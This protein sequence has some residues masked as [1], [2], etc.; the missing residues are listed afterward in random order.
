[1]RFITEFEIR[2]EDNRSFGYRKVVLFNQKANRQIEMGQMLADSFGWQNP[3]NSNPLH[4]RLGIEAFPMDKWIEFKQ[5]LFE[6]LHVTGGNVSGV[7]VLEL[8]KEIESFGKPVT[9]TP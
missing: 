9:N 5:K 4:H 7:R 2:E 1:M 8:I 3:V 6:Y